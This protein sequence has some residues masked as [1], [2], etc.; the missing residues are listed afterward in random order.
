VV[1]LELTRMNGMFVH[2]FE[3]NESCMLHSVGK[4]V[5]M[6]FEQEYKNWRYFGISHDFDTSYMKTWET[7]SIISISFYCFKKKRKTHE[8]SSVWLLRK[9]RAVILVSITSK[10]LQK[11]FSVFSSYIKRN[12]R[13]I[14]G[15]KF[16]KIPVWRQT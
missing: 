4:L 12:S 14:S 11:S 15:S 6:I 3:T 16:C 1:I 5:T 13:P 2:A 7:Q 10:E 8:F 9:I